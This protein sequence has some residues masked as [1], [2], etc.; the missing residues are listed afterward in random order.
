M[1]NF[2]LAHMD[3]ELQGNQQALARYLDLQRIF[4]HSLYIVS[5][6]QHQVL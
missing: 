1:K 3:L 4:P 6:V 5:Q 2:F